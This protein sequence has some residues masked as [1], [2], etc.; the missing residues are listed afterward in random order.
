MPTSKPTSGIASLQHQYYFSAKNYFEACKPKVVA[1]MLFTTLVGMFLASPEYIPWVTV[2]AGTTGIGLIAGAAAAFNQIADQHIDAIMQR[3]RS[4]PL[5]AGHLEKKQVIIFACLISGAGTLILA[6]WV[7]LLTTTLALLSLIGYSLIYTRFLKYATPQNIVIGGAAGAT[8]P[9]L[10]WIAVTGQIETQALL[11]FLIIFVWT[12][13]H[14]WALALYRKEDY[15]NAKVPMLPVTHGEDF[16]RLHILLYTLLL[17]AVTML[18]YIIGMSGSVY[19]FGAI[20][21]NS[22]F[23]YYTIGLKITGSEYWAKNTFIYS[24]TYILLLFALLLLDMHLPT[25]GKSLL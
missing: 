6:I 16:T 3:T 24:I 14:F 15:A 12:P 2:V 11:L 18:P 7:N 22:V 20:L 21:L 19:L 13:P 5:P 1:T 9:L 10:G 23:L 8:P 25:I 17:A 4:R